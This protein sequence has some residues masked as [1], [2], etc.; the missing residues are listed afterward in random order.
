MAFSFELP[1][2]FAVIKY[3]VLGFMFAAKD[4]DVGAMVRAAPVASIAKVQ[5]MVFPLREK[6]VLR[7]KFS[8]VPLLIAIAPDDR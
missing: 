5:M 6:A 8:M 1:P 7:F 4:D 2:P 3:P